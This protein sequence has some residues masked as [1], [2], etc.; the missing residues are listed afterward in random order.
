MIREPAYVGGYSL[1]SLLAE[2]GQ[3]L[4]HVRGFL[5]DGAARAGEN[6]WIALAE[7]APPMKG[8]ESL[9]GAAGP[10]RAKSQTSAT[11]PRLKT[12]RRRNQIRN[13]LA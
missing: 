12:R 5:C 3:K 11:G 13:V 7:S 8:L 4:E 1:N 6:D 2:G 10:A 9:N